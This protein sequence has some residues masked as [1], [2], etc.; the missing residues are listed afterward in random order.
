MATSA[1]HRPLEGSSEVQVG[2]SSELPSPVQTACCDNLSLL[3]SL[4]DEHCD[5]IYA[6]PP[7]NC[8]RTLGPAKSA[9]H[10]FPDRHDGGP[11]GYRAFL[12]PRLAEMHRVLSV[13]GSLYVHLDWHA[14][15]HVR[16]LLDEIFS[17]ENF[18]NE[19]VW[20]YRSGGRPGRWFGRKHD[21]ILLYAKQ[22]GRHTFHQQRGG[23]YRTQGLRT[24]D[25]GVLYKNTQ[26]GRIYFDPAGPVLSD[27]WDIPFLS[28]VSKQRTGYPTQKPVA[29]L[30]R[31]I[32]ASSNE[33]DL[34]G[35]FFCGSGTTLVAAVELDRRGIGCDINPDAVALTRQRLDALDRSE[36]RPRS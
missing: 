13:T 16:V 18:L 5:L 36:T 4:P 24:L 26:N 20:A 34:V 7:F 32:R 30:E 12:R 17:A 19:I 35:D 1:H 11:E 14:C 21:T 23:A 6:D 3:A 15:H 27:V 2:P 25:D 22:V 31:I 8:N 9:Q 33:G 10:T 28:T 29:L